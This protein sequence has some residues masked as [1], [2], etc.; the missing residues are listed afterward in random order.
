MR[1]GQQSLLR[2]GETTSGAARRRGEHHQGSREEGRA[3]AGQQRGGE[4]ISRAAE[5]RG[6]ASGGRREHVQQDAA[7]Q[8][9]GP[10]MVTCDR[11]IAQ[12]RISLS[13]TNS[14]RT[15]GHS[16]GTCGRRSEPRCGRSPVT[17]CS[18]REGEERLVSFASTSHATCSQGTPAKWLNGQAGQTGQWIWH[19]LDRSTLRSNLR[20]ALTSHSTTP[21]LHPGREVAKRVGEHEPA[22]RVAG[23]RAQHASWMGP[24]GE[25]L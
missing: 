22:H 16:S 25:R 13:S 23:A 4:S 19:G 20:S 6:S 8:M 24:P 7:L 18:Q 9:V 14:Q 15:C 3:S 11:N 12:Q 10:G 1:V 5:K 21:R 17:I 2:G